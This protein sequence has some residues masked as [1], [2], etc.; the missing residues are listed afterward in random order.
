MKHLPKLLVS[1][2][3]CFGVAY[4]GSVSTISSITGWYA[5]LNKPFFNPPNWVFGPVWTL[6]YFLMAV[7]VY[8]VW[9]KGVTKKTKPALLLFA[10][11]LVLNY[12]WSY[13]FFG[14]QKPLLAFVEILLLWFAIY[15]TIVRFKSISKLASNLLIPYILWV[16]FAVVL[17][18]GIVIINR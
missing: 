11:Q 9:K 5:S 2:A 17:N 16:S 14:L 3:A 13:F 7:S 12:L 6:L 4:L 8:L 18:L 10:V 15:L 1:F